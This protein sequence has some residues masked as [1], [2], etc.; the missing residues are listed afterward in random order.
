MFLI[1]KHTLKLEAGQKDRRKDETC[2][3]SFF[4][5]TRQMGKIAPF[6]GNFLQDCISFPFFRIFGQNF[7]YFRQF[8][9]KFTHNWAIF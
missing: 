7:I 8:F 1:K 3:G 4:G 2:F 6:E 9:S 5:V